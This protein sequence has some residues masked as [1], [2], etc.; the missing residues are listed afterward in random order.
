MSLK[1][2]KLT[3]YHMVN[4]QPPVGREE[5]SSSMDSGTYGEFALSCL[6]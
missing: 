2:M 6:S 4:T 5:F 3:V 1:T